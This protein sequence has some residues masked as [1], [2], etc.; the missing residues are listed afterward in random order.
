MLDVGGRR[1]P[2]TLVGWKPRSSTEYCLSDYTTIGVACHI[3]TELLGTSQ[4]VSHF[5]FTT[6]RVH[7]RDLRHQV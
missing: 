4:L 2:A 1:Y 6:S 5:G 7:G 3:I